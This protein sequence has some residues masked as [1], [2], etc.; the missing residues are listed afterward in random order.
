MGKIKGKIIVNFLAIIAYIIVKIFIKD[1]KKVLRITVSFKNTTKDIK[2]YTT[3]K[4]MEEQSEFIKVAI[5]YY[6]NHFKK[7]KENGSI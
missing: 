1:V 5:E 7:E 6:L 4:A 3:V 2:L